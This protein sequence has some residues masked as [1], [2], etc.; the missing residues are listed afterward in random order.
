MEKS[1]KQTKYQHCLFCLPEVPVPEENQ[2]LILRQLLLCIIGDEL[3]RQ[4]ASLIKEHCNGCIVDHA[5]QIQ[6]QC[7]ELARIHVIYKTVS[8]D[9]DLPFMNAVFLECANIKKLNASLIDFDTCA[10]E[11]L[12]K[13]ENKSFREGQEAGNGPFLLRIFRKL[14]KTLDSQ[15]LYRRVDNTWKNRHW[16]NA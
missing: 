7:V 15:H 13:W 6:H 2:K 11:S 10:T 9:L 1:Q 5:S 3:E 16:S 12:A 14:Y 8:A 4:T